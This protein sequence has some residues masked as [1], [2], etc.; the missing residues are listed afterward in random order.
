MKKPGTPAIDDDSESGSAGVSAE[1]FGA[2]L[3][4]FGFA[5]VPPAAP[6]DF[7]PDFSEL[8]VVLGGVV[9]FFAPA[10][11]VPWALWPLT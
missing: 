10:R 7:A 9:R 2:R 4:R 3:P 6:R 5:T 11:V 1:G 8:G